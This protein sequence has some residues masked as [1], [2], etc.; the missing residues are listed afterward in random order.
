MVFQNEMQEGLEDANKSN[1]K[2]VISFFLGMRTT[3]I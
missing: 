1:E 3:I 2:S